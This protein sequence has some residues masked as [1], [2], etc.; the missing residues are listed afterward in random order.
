VAPAAGR[1]S[2][3]Y[4]GYEE[5]GPAHP[6]RSGPPPY[7]KPLLRRWMVE[8]AHPEVF[9][10]LLLQVL[11]DGR[12]NRFPGDATVDFRNRRWVMTS[13]T[14]P[15]AHP[16]SAPVSGHS[17]RQPKPNLDA[18]IDE[19]RGGRH[20]PASSA[21]NFLN[22]IDELIASR[23]LSAADLQAHRALAGWLS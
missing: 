17:R 3:G 16:S 22:R 19:G 12:L 14:W 2:P 15:A 1:P 13:P 11:D 8:K 23:P 7:E 20:S 6:R 5:G 4:V 21:Q 10:N 9:F 18:A